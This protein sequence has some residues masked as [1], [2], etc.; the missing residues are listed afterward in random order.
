MENTRRQ[1]VVGKAEV[2]AVLL[3]LAGKPRR[4]AQIG[5][6]DFAQE[7]A[8]S[9]VLAHAA[10][11]IDHIQGEEIPGARAHRKH[12]LALRDHI[13]PVGGTGIGGNGA[14]D[15]PVG[16]VAIGLDK[17]RVARGVDHRRV[18]VL[19]DQYRRRPRLRAGKIDEKQAIARG[20]IRG[21]D[22]QKTIV[23]GNIGA[24]VA[25]FLLVAGA[26][27]EFVPRL[28]GSDAVKIQLVLIGFGRQR[29][30]GGLVVA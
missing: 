10:Q 5:Q 4:R 2:Q 17:D 29:A 8:A 26:E 13:L 3:A 19:I 16:R 23:L 15:P 22:T 18:G 1:A 12:V 20:R 6:C 24:H 28:R 14:H 21:A 7:F 11:G 25:V 30:A 27:Y 9:R